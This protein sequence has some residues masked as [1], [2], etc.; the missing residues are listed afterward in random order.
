[1]KE[2][3]ISSADMDSLLALDGRRLPASE[4]QRRADIQRAAR[5]ARLAKLAQGPTA[6]LRALGVGESWVFPG[7]RAQAL[8]PAIAGLK[9]EGLRF[10]TSQEGP[11]LRVTRIA[12]EHPA[13]GLT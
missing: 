13:E 2:I 11:D 12:A 9:A 7:K 10:R 5:E 8:S 6:R 1:M 4:W 3:R